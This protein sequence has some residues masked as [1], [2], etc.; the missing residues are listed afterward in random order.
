MSGRLG[1]QIRF[2][3]EADRLKIVRRQSVLL[4]GSRRE[5][6]AEHSWHVALAALVLQEHA[7]EPVKIDRVVTLL[8]LHDLVEIDAGD[9]FLYDDAANRDKREREERA[10]ERVFGLL[11]SEQREILRDAW[12]EFED[13]RTPEARFAAAVDRLLPVLHNTHHDGAL[14][15]ERGVGRARV[16]E[17]NRPMARAAQRLWRWA[18]SRIHAAFAERSR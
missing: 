10:A 17:R 8:L 16:I 3:E 9:T 5:N 11:P 14:W 13:Q 18:E 2:L 6:S 12:R 7:D 4:D 1:R 15:K